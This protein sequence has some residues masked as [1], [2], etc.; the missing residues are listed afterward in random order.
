MARPSDRPLS[1]V[2][3]EEGGQ[4]RKDP[5]L[6]PGSSGEEG[7][8]G[9]LRLELQGQR[10]CLQPCQVEGQGHHPQASHADCGGGCFL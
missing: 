7:G 3:E 8:G 1:T 2:E 6:V 9:W 10:H 4:E 5:A